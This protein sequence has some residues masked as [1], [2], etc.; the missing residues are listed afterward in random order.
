MNTVPEE[1]TRPLT[2]A[3]YRVLYGEDFIQD[4]ILSII[5]YCDKI[6]VFW[7]DVPWGDVKQAKYKGNI[8]P[9]PKLIDRVVDSVK[10]LAIKFPNKI[11]IEFD[12][13]D[14]NVNQVTHLVNDH[15]LHS[16]GKPDLLIF[17]EWVISC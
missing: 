12:H 1:T 5:D 3:I 15:I 8:I 10:E 4:S 14:V 6:F 13:S 2:Y 17:M 7:D 9:I 16:Y 11:V